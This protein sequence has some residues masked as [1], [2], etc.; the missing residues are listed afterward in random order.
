MR[1]SYAIPKSLQSNLEIFAYESLKQIYIALKILVMV[2][3]SDYV[4]LVMVA[5]SYG[6]DLVLIQ[7]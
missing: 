5:Y 3:Y 6:V 7:Y 1:T 2:A 4:D